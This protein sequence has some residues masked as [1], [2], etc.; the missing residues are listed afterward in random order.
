[1]YSLIFF[2]NLLIKKCKRNHQDQ[3]FSQPQVPYSKEFV[4][5][6]DGPST[7]S[8]NYCAASCDEIKTDMPTCRHANGWFQCLWFFP[9]LRVR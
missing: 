2:K 7:W 8:F 3:I 6:S 5:K 4:K 1:M 9:E